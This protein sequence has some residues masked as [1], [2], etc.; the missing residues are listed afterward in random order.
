MG[1][2]IDVTLDQ[3]VYDG[4]VKYLEQEFG[5]ARAKSL[6]VNVAVR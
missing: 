3:D 2:P 6:I 4:L 1:K 5:S